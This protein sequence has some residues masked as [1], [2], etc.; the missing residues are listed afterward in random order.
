[1]EAFLEGR[2]P[3]PAIAATVEETLTRQTSREPG[4]IEEVLAIDA[5]SRELARKIIAEAH[6]AAAFQGVSSR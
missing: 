4:T 3:F 1:M 6:P 5:E 2:I